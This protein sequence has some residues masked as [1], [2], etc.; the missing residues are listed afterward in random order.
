MKRMNL[1]CALLLASVMLS[2]VTNLFV[3]ADAMASGFMAGWN[4]AGAE[5]NNEGMV[6]SSCELKPKVS[7]YFFKTVSKRD[8][9]VIA[10]NP[11]AIDYH[12]VAVKDAYGAITNFIA[13]IIGVFMV[14]LFLYLWWVFF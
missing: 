14:G 12:V 3:G 13:M 10:F 11:T 1:L 5:Y 6:Y 8:G 2:F 7:D 4:Q 9:G